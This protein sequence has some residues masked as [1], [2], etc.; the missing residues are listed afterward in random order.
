MLLRGNR[1]LKTGR[2]FLRL[3]AL[4]RGKRL[5]SEMDDELRFH[6]DKQIEDNIAGGM[7][8]EEAR[9]AALRGFGGVEQIK[10]QCRDARGIRLIREIWQDLRYGMRMLR[11]SPAF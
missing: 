8:R 1:M 7:T 3:R 11:R 10:E 2:L 9:T 4:L 6:L 5:E